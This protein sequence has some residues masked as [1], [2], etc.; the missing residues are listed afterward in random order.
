MNPIQP[1][2]DDVFFMQ[3]ALKEAARAAEAGEVPIG[4]VVVADHKIIVRGH[5]QVERL[6]DPT[7]HAELLAITAAA[8]YFN[9]KY[10]PNCTLYVT[11]EPC[12]MCSGALYWSQIKRLVFGASDPKRGYQALAKTALHPRTAVQAAI[13]AKESNQLLICFFKKLR[14]AI[15]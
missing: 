11:L 13:L 8:D 5:N 6:K 3:A 2:A 14:N 15:L 12:I 4:A 1:I 10:L 9:S 7:A